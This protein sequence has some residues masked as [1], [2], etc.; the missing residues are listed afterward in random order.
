VRNTALRVACVALLA[1][2]APAVDAAPPELLARHADRYDLYAPTAAQLDTSAREIEHALGVFATSFGAPPP[3]VA[4]VVVD[5]PDALRSLDLARF[6]PAGGAVLPWVTTSYLAGGERNLNANREL[7]VVLSWHPERGATVLSMLPAAAGDTTAV[8]GLRVGDVIRSIDGAP[9]G[10]LKDFEDRFDGVPPGREVALGVGRGAGEVTLRALKRAS[11]GA[12]PRVQTSGN[13]AAKRALSHEVGHLLL[14]AWVD[15]RLDRADAP[16]R[17]SAATGHYG[18]DVLPDW[19][20]EAFAT[21]CE[22][23]LLQSSR[24]AFMREKLDQRI[25]LAELFTMSH[26]VAQSQQELIARARQQM[27]PGQKSAMIVMRGDGALVSD[28]SLIFYAQ[29]LS[30]ADFLAEREGPRVLGRLAAGLSERREITELLA[31]SSRL[32]SDLAAL[33]AA[34]TSWVA[35]GSHD[36]E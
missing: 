5:S 35:A 23:P 20:D 32:P 22:F 13:A 24:R 29:C 25:P 4:V 18:I 10:S 1:A 26:P 31:E 15:A 34:W 27:A 11:S 19:L 12:A 33:E 17:D 7:G 2:S 9:V 16:A 3:R 21:R 30:I 8:P 28:R 36:P 14:K 6:R